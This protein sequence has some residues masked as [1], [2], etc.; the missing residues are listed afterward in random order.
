MFHTMYTMF[1]I[2]ILAMG[3]HIVS[4][5]LVS[6]R[7]MGLANHEVLDLK[8]KIYQFAN[9]RVFRYSCEIQSFNLTFSPCFVW[10]RFVRRIYGPG[11]TARASGHQQPISLL[12]QRSP[13]LHCRAQ[14]QMPAMLHWMQ[15]NLSMAIAESSKCLSTV[16][17]WNTTR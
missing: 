14:R 5:W 7:R 4:N 1:H 3:I 9:F 16:A 10:H 2:P 17:S 13:L 11:T 12:R 6:Q 15:L 8:K